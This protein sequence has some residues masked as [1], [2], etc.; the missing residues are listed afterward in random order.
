M[1]T[2]ISSLALAALALALVGASAARAQL[3]FEINLD[4]S[5]LV[6][7]GS[8]PFSLDFQLNEG[9]GTLANTVTLSN[10]VFDN[11]SASGSATIFGTGSGD[12]SSSITLSSSSASAFNELYQGFADGTTG[13]HFLATVSQNTAGATPDM[14]AVAVLDSSL[15]PLATN[16]GDMASLVTLSIDAANTIGDVGVYSSAS[17][18]VT[19]SVSAVPEP[20]TTTAG[21]GAAALALVGF[22]R[23]R[24]RA[25]LA[26]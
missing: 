7:S 4:T 18:A 1:K 6:G 16:A 13:I 24:K 26:A 11:G 20:A 14:F 15:N 22:L 21:L 12:L 3:Q 5:G 19:A 17:P 10:F 8:A 9:S 25:Q 2:R 23:S